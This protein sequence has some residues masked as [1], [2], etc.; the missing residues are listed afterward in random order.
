MLSRDSIVNGDWL[1]ATTRY[2]LIP[3]A[4][5]KIMKQFGGGKYVPIMQHTAQGKDFELIL[6][7]I[8]LAPYGTDGRLFTTDVSA[9]FK[10][11]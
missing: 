1:C 8:K 11:Q 2:P 6:T 3:N 9:N 10:S 4:V 7:L 5:M